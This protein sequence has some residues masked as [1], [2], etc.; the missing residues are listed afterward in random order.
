[1][2]IDNETTDAKSKN[3]IEQ[4]KIQA[5]AD[6]K[7]TISQLRQCEDVIQNKI[8]QLRQCSGD[9]LE[10]ET[11]PDTREKLN[12]EKKELAQH[13]DHLRSKLKAEKELII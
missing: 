4:M 12:F 7:T 1:M 3:A 10:V 8:S 9:K 11:D 2:G 13:E 5:E 6:L